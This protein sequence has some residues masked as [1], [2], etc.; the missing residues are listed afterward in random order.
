LY[1]DAFS[2]S[3]LERLSAQAHFL[4]SDCLPLL[5]RLDLWKSS[6]GFSV[7][8]FQAPDCLFHDVS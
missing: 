7:L 8:H 2:E 5:L 6:A 3:R 4:Q 1:A